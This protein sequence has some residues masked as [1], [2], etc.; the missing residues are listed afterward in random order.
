MVE[1]VYTAKVMYVDWKPEAYVDHHQMGSY[2]ARFYVP[3]YSEPIRPYADP[4]IWRELS[5][6]GAHI[7]YKLEEAGKSGV[8]NAGQYPGWG[9]FGWHWITPFHNMTGML[10][11]SASA[12]LATPR[13]TMPDCQVY[14]VYAGFV[15]P[16]P[17]ASKAVA[18][19]N[20]G[21]P[22]LT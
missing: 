21:P 19:P 18:S 20:A 15:E 2:G 22:P 9:H 16:S 10:T 1:A 14:A 3:P 11:E 17:N 4:L 6:Y 12:S 7:A 5:W 13:A 8:L